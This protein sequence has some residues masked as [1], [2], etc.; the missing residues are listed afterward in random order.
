MPIHRQCSSFHKSLTLTI[1]QIAGTETNSRQ[2]TN[3]DTQSNTNRTR[4]NTI[5]KFVQINVGP[6]GELR[7]YFSSEVDLRQIPY[8]DSLF[9]S[10]A[11]VKFDNIKLPDVHPGAFGQLLYFIRTGEF[12]YDLEK[13]CKHSIDEKIFSPRSSEIVKTYT[14]AKK[15][16]VEDCMNAASDCIRNA[17]TYIKLTAGD[18]LH[19]VQNCD[20][21]DPLFRL[22]MQALASDVHATGWSRWRDCNKVWYQA[23]T[24]G[25]QST[26]VLLNQALANYQGAEHPPAGE[27]TCIWHIHTTTP[28][29]IVPGPTAPEV[30]LADM[31]KPSSSATEPIA[32]SMTL[33]QAF[34]VLKAPSHSPQ[35][36]LPHARSSIPLA[37]EL[38]IASLNMGLTDTEANNDVESEDDDED[39]EATK[40][41]PKSVTETGIAGVD[42]GDTELVSIEAKSETGTDVSEDDGE[43]DGDEEATNTEAKSESETGFSDAETRISEVD[44]EDKE[45]AETEARSE[46]ETG[47]LENGIYEAE[48]GMSEVETECSESAPIASESVDTGNSSTS[49]TDTDTDVDT[50]VDTGVNADEASNE[51]TAT[52]SVSSVDSE[53]DIQVEEDSVTSLKVEKHTFDLN[54][55]AK[56]DSN[57]EA[58]AIESSGDADT[59]AAMEIATV[60]E[61]AVEGLSQVNLTHCP[62]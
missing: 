9:D 45:A 14:L 34:P 48:T 27:K 46:S 11:G 12:Q 8:F 61:G 1:S 2:K 21:A 31:A 29:C 24:E 37:D 19:V 57:M 44:D 60:E 22:S 17:L 10:M 51:A 58:A 28:P 42:Y 39:E 35:P 55:S 30:D 54:T 4:T 52:S 7:G 15:F 36:L 23:F 20:A 50:D 16:G 59:A 13:L 3:S 6:A 18:M 40:A 49:S 26:I 41:E 56:A 25:E 38:D 5:S 32:K 43:D 62:S 33:S 53:T 47:I